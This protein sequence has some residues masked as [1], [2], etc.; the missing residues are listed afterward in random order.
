MGADSGIEA[1][2][3]RAQFMRESLENSQKI[4][5]TM[6]GILGSFDNRL[7]TLETAMRPTQVKTH[8]FRKAHDN[9][10]STLEAAQSV[11]HQFEISRQVEDKVLEGPKSD[12]RGFL[13]ACDQLHKNIEYLTL[14]RSLKASDTALNHATEVYGK[15]MSRLEEEFRVLLKNN[16]K[17]ADPVRLMETLPIPGKH[18]P[19]TPQNGGEEVK[20]LLTNTPYNDKALNPPVLPVLIAPKFI[21]QLAEMTQRLVSAGLHQQ[22]LKIYRDVRASNLEESLRKLGVERLSKDDIMKMPWESL[23]GKITNWIQYMRIAIKLLF[24]AERKLCDQ[25]WHRLDPY[26]EKCFADVTDSSVHM[27]LSFGEAIAKS[28]KTPEKL[29]VL[30]DMYE[31][32]RDLQPEIELVF[33]G[34]AA[35]GMREAATG[36]I[37]R[38]GQTAKDTFADFEDAVDKDATKTLVLDGTV[39]MLTSYVINYVKFLLDYQNTLNELFSDSVDDKTSHLAAATARI[40]QVLQTNLEGKAK[41]YKDVALSHLFLMNNIHYMVKSVRRSEAKDMLGDDWVQRQRRVV[42]QHGIS[43]QRNAWNKVL[44]YITGSGGASSG[45]SGISKSQLKERLKGFSLT[46]EDLYLRQTQWTI[47]DNELRE[48]VRLQVQEII[49]PAY[50]SFLKRYNAM[51]EGKQNVNKYLKYSPDDLERMLNDLFEGKSRQEPRARQEGR[52]PGR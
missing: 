2:V 18:V 42:Q 50:R 3:A 30:L 19:E 23:E 8:A 47:P 26:R 40:M 17:P 27:L 4:T 38:L 21:P 13:T 43:Y 6:I 31:T 14:N 35:T 45:D 52:P 22:C 41:L 1:F 9:I 12:L 37:K 5:D 20:L 7:S 44:Q 11:L 36:L 10:D 48:A 15:G 33:S 46:F 34:D 16:S 39:H 25:I 32:M 49:L 29:F 28:K 24:S 51:I